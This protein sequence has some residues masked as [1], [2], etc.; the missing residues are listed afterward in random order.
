MRTTIC[1]LIATVFGAVCV[2]AADEPFKIRKPIEIFK[3]ESPKVV[4]EPAKDYDPDVPT[5][6]VP[7]AGTKYT[8]S[9]FILLANGRDNTRIDP[10]PIKNMEDKRWHQPG[11]LLGVK[12]WKVEK[13]KYLPQ[14]TEVKT[15]IGK[16]EVENS[17]PNGLRKPD[18]TPDH[19]R[20]LNDGLQRQYPDG[21]RFDEVL[22][23]ADT[24][25]VFEHRVRSKEEGKWRSV[26][27]F[28]DEDARPAG[29]AGLKVTCSSCHKEAGTGKYADG[30]V[31]GG[32]TV[33]SDPLPWHLWTR[34]PPDK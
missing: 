32:D 18:G 29:Y 5:G 31:P 30:L 25:K 28:K 22:R 16:I 24:G 15:W 13:F 23:N 34:T 20:Q 10:F 1:A 6:A 17:I 3:I 33:L 27:H 2:A 19:F 11:G 8:Q 7:F 12:G 9:I 4:V 26:V 21:T 14:G